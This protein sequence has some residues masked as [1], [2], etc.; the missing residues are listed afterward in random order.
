MSRFFAF[1]LLAFAPLLA[2][3]S[4]ATHGNRLSAVAIQDKPQDLTGIWQVAGEDGDK[5]Y[6]GVLLIRQEDDGT[7]NVR[8]S[9]I[10]ST[11]RG[12]GICKGNIL[13]VGWAQAIGD[14][15]IVGVTVYEISKD[16][17]S[18]DGEWRQIGENNAPRKERAKWLA[19]IKPSEI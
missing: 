18:L 3:T 17:K 10:G 7:Y 19:K 13:S 1:L 16:G 6:H 2:L 5:A 15:H 11:T 14:S 9:T 4:F 12:V 8:V